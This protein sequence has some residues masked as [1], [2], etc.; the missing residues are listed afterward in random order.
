MRFLLFVFLFVFF[1]GWSQNGNITGKVTFEN[2]ES[3]FG[4]SVLISGTQNFVI[5]DNDGQFEIKGLA[6]GNY[7][8]EISSIEAKT[9]TVN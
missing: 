6:Y 8:L 9:K 7:V 4:A 2:A 1:Q 3:A 5:V